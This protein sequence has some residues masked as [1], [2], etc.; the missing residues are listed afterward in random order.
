[1]G[2]VRGKTDHGCRL[3][4]LFEQPEHRIDIFWCEA[5][6]KSVVVLYAFAAEAGGIADPLFERDGTRHQLVELKFR[7]NANS[8]RHT[9]GI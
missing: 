9:A 6:E 8:G 5:A 2:K 1:M 3:T 4:G 7:E